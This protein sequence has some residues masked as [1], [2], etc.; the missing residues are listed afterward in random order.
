MHHYTLMN[1]CIGMHLLHT[2]VLWDLEVV[3]SRGN[4]TPHLMSPNATTYILYYPLCLCITVYG[5]FYDIPARAFFDIQVDLNYRKQWDHLMV[6]V[7]I[8]ETD[9]KSGCEVVKWIQHFPVRI[10]IPFLFFFF[11]FFIFLQ[12]N[13]KCFALNYGST[14][15]QLLEGKTQ[16]LIVCSVQEN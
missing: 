12:K 1:M 16:R 3:L 9:K 7:E 14:T 10:I 13:L 5:T 4:S 15:L 11:I 6:K 8:V 2:W